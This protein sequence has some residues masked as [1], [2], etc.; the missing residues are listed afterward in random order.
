VYHEAAVSAL[1]QKKIEP[2]H[3]SPQLRLECRTHLRFIFCTQGNTVTNR[4]LG[5]GGE[6]HSLQRIL[7]LCTFC[8]LTSLGKSFIRLAPCRRRTQSHKNDQSEK[9]NAGEGYFSWV[10]SCEG[11]HTS[12]PLNVLPLIESNFTRANC[13]TLFW[14]AAKT[15]ISSRVVLART[16]L[17]DRLERPSMRTSSI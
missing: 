17:D 9:N 6:E 7:C 4:Q 15:T 16:S 11:I 1:S 5:N 8:S 3:S 14:D 12:S 2:P 13:P 10:F